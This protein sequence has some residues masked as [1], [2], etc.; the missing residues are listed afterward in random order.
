MHEEIL[1]NS[2]NKLLTLLS[3]FLQN[4][5]LVGGTAI[6][7]QIGHRRS[8][9]FDMATID[10]LENGK[11]LEQIKNT[12]EVQKTIVDETNEITIVVDFVKLT[13]IKYPFKIDFE[14]NF[15]NILKM[16]SMVT[17]AAMKA[18]AL[19]RRAKWK[20]YVDLYFIF[21]TYSFGDVVEKAKSIFGNEF[22]EKQFREQLTYFEDIDYTE[23]IDY[24]KGIGV[25]DKEIKQY[26]IDISL[27]K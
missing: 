21:Q 14:V 24:T 13:F 16:P 5:G 1:S 15:N 11:I 19:G 26:L 17:L 2:Q 8:I 23:K 7:L 6:A 22:N 25:D 12:H 20:D 27:Q 3:S 10:E 4:F 9:D 18:Y